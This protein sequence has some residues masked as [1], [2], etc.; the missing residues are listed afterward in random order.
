MIRN[1]IVLF[2]M[3]SL[4]SC[5]MTSDTEESQQP[6]RIRD[7]EN[8]LVRGVADY[9]Q[10]DYLQ[11]GI[12]FTRALHL[13]RSIDNPQGIVLSCINLAKTSLVTGDILRAEAFVDKAK[14]ILHS[15]LLLQREHLINYLAIVDS[16]IKIE[17]MEYHAAKEI[18]QPLLD[19]AYSKQSE[20]NIAAV[21]NRLRIAIEEQASDAFVWM[22][23]YSD[24]LQ[25]SESPRLNQNA[26]L[27]RFKAAL[28]DN[29]EEQNQNYNMA[30]NLYRQAAHRM[31]IAATLEEWAQQQ[32]EN[33]YYHAAANKLRR[34]LFIRIE[35]KDRRNSQAILVILQKIYRQSG[36][37]AKEKQSVLWLEQ[38]SSVEFAQWNNLLGDYN[39]YP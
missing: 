22:Q 13:Y 23:S 20:I 27:L 18:L 16:S 28:N 19:T 11:A 14:S 17:K 39:N 9:S 32:Y 26:R 37:R 8:L 7:A 3:M 1:T 2:L 5:A 10:S 6:E 34:A 4:L 38:L 25:L 24:L 36:N 29:V 31:G 33:Q 15:S 21:Q 12:F 30:L 35:L